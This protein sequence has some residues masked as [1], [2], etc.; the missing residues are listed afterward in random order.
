MQQLELEQLLAQ[1]QRWLGWLPALQVEGP[2]GF[3][4]E[5]ELRLE[6]LRPLQQPVR[7]VLRAG[8]E[9]WPESGS[10]SP[11]PHVGAPAPS[12]QG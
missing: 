4:P 7:L 11:R 12:I 2:A 10:G 8:P 3:R 1:L 9:T 5:V 6:R